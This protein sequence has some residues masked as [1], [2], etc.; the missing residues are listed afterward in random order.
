MLYDGSPFAAKDDI[1]FDF[2]DLEAMTFFGT[3]AK[4]IETL[5]NRGVKPN[6]THELANLRTIASTGSPL[7]PAGFDY[8]YENVKN[9]VCLSSISGGTDIIACFVCGNPT[10]PVW[11][12]EIQVRALGMATEVF[13]TDGNS[14]IGEKGELVYRFISLYAYRFLE[15]RDGRAL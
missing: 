5:A 2:A 4:Y 14:V 11:R 12:G 10:G 13:D 15:G 9:D 7:S 3:S 8:V 6:Q 1:L